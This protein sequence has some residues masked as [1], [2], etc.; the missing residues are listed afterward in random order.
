MLLTSMYAPA[1][2][3][4]QVLELTAQVNALSANNA[5][6][7]SQIAHLRNAVDAAQND[8]AAEAAKSRDYID[9]LDALR[10]MKEHNQHV[11]FSLMRQMEKA[12][13]ERDEVFDLLKDMQNRLATADGER[14]AFRAQVIELVRL[15]DEMLAQFVA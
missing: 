15:R 1:L 13:S 12:T 3:F 9:E 7:S 11:M 5:E 4:V 8:A 14:T 6:Q 10:L 2:L